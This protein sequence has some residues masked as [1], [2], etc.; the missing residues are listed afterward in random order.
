MNDW[1]D[2]SSST[3]SG[4]VI[5]LI[6]RGKKKK[7]VVSNKPPPATHPHSDESLC[8]AAGL[9]Q[10]VTVTLAAAQRV[11]Y[12][13]PKCVWLTAVTV[14]SFY[15]DLKGQTEEDLQSSSSCQLFVLI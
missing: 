5:C 2:L 13:Q 1:T 4:L 11:S 9:R 6:L 10:S 12:R 3:R 14:V 15:V 7:S 8:L